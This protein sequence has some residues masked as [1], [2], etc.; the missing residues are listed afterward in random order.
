MDQRVKDAR[1]HLGLLASEHD[2][3]EIMARR[4]AAA[5]I[6]DE[7]LND[8]MKR[9]VGMTKA[10]STRGQE[11]TTE[12]LLD[13]FHNVRNEGGYGANLWTLYNAASEYADHSG[14]SKDNNNRLNSNL[15]GSSNT[16]KQRAW[17]IAGDMLETLAA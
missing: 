9:L 1:R 16:F 15:F 13:V 14:R 4:M 7:M 6:N 2:K 8:Y 12:A 5:Q 3:Y 10:K 17:A 11:R